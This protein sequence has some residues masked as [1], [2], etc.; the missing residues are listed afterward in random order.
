MTQQVKRTELAR[1]VKHYHTLTDELLATIAEWNGS[2]TPNDVKAALEAGK[3][4]YT[5][6]SK[7]ELCK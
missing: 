1:D 5:S 4:V 6:F 3:T 7:W 2:M